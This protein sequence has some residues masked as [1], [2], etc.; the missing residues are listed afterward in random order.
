MSKSKNITIHHEKTTVEV[1]NLNSWGYAPH[2]TLCPAQS[3]TGLCDY[4]PE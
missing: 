1:R 2:Y 4:Q 3:E